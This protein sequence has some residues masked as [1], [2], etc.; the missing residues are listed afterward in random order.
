MPQKIE[1]PNATDIDSI[2]QQLAHARELVHSVLGSGLNGTESDLALLQRVLD[3]KVVEPEA[4]YSLQTLGIAFGHVFINNNQDYDLWMVEDE[5]GRDPAIRF[6][7]TSL[8][9]FPQTMLSKRIED[10]EHVD[11]AQLY[12]VLREDL[13]AIR[14]DNY[15]SS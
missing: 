11:V 12:E 9:V 15:A 10:G 8:L 1:A 13:E 5:Y 7:Q 2:A 3:A 14:R 6:K 4:T